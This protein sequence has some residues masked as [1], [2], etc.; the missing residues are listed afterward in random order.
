MF[1]GVIE[2]VGGKN[3]YQL[4]GFISR[5]AQS[6]RVAV[7]SI[8][9][10]DLSPAYPGLLVRSGHEFSGSKELDSEKFKTGKKLQVFLRLCTQR[11][12]DGENRKLT[13][14]CGSELDAFVVRRA[15]EA[16]LTDVTHQVLTVGRSEFS[17]AGHKSFIPFADVQIDGI[18][19]DADQ[20]ASALKN[21]I[22]KRRSM[23]MGMILIG[24]GA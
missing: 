12:V 20:F 14:L 5:W 1:E 17:K 11:V 21:G 2:V 19:S 4:H 13:I 8:Q 10:F 15:T 3:A 22:G 18:V 7:D 16:G 24:G 6:E 9:F 23:G